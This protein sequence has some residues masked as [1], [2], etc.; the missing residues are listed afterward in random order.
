LTTEIP[1]YLDS[2]AARA[3]A[4][5]NFL[6]DRTAI[7]EMDKINYLLAAMNR[8]PA[9][10]IRNGEHFDGAKASGWLRWKMRHPQYKNNPIL[11]AKDFVSRVSFRSEKTGFPYEVISAE[12]N[13]HLLRDVLSH[14]LIV[15]ENAISDNSFPAVL[16][17]KGQSFQNTQQGLPAPM[18]LPA[19][20]R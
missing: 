4:L 13:R 3:A 9:N 2:G 18:I 15:L 12:G 5:Q 20:S 7:S 1:L 6:K 17:E 11:T 10:F 16:S 14:E 19:P 8:S